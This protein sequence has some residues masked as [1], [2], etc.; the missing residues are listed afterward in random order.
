MPG[1]FCSNCWFRKTDEYGESHLS[2]MKDL[3]EGHCVLAG[4]PCDHPELAKVHEK[5]VSC[6][7]LIAFYKGNDYDPKPAKIKA[8]KEGCKLYEQLHLF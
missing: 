3:K 5:I 2:W 1:Y 6:P 4:G 8:R 7:R